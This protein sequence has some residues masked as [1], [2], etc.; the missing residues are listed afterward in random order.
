MMNPT[1]AHTRETYAA[2]RTNALLDDLDRRLSAL[3]G[4]YVAGL[5]REDEED[6]EV[7]GADR[8]RLYARVMGRNVVKAADA[9]LDTEAW[10]AQ[11]DAS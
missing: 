6:S 9:L 11:E 3:R 7:S 8:A 10:A 4:S 2:Q 1:F 5:R